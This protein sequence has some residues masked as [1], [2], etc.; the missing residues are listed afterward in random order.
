MS[1][2]ES[3]PNPEKHTSNRTRLGAGTWIEI[4][5]GASAA[6]VAS[7]LKAVVA[8]P[9]ACLGCLIVWGIMRFWPAPATN[10]QPLNCHA[11]PPKP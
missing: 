3:K 5:A 7:G 4:W 1:D 9:G 11:K 8:L 10:A 6:T 2:Q